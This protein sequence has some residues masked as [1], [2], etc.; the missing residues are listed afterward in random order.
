[1]PPL[2]AYPFG[3]LQSK[4]IERVFDFHPPLPYRKIVPILHV[5]HFE[6]CVKSVGFYAC[7]S[8]NTKSNKNKTTLAT[9][10]WFYIKNSLVSFTLTN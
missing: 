9:E 2:G 8:D 10:M 5:F 4:S 3:R 6:K 7:V 1:M